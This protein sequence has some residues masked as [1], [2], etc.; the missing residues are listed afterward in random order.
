MARTRLLA[1]EW[2]GLKLAVES[3]V[4][5]S[6][7]WPPEIA[8]RT[9]HPDD[10]DVH[11]SVQ[12]LRQQRVI[13]NAVPYSHEGSLFE[14]GRRGTDHCLGV[15]GDGRVARFDPDFRW[16]DVWLP[17]SAIRNRVFPLAR[18]LDDLLVIHRALVLGALAVRATAAVRQGRALVVLGDAR[19]ANL[20]PGTAMWEGWLLLDPRPDGTRVHPLPSTHETGARVRGEVLLEGLHVIDSVAND[21]SLTR[22]LDP[23]IA[24]GE[25]LRFAFAPLASSSSTDRMLSAA[26]R[27]AGRV[28]LLRVGAAIGQRFA[29]R[30]ARSPLTRVPPAGA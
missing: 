18:P 4:G 21:D 12:S 25:I 22:T 16:G 27:L 15:A 5:C 8:D 30:R 19:P 20:Q 9:C 3:P 24:A 28:S 26:T 13:E 6:W 29:W 23:E 11:V 10:P 14:A 7:E 1:F 2:A 17:P